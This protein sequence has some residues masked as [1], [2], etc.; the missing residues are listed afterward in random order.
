MSRSESITIT[1]PECKHK[2]AIVVWQSINATLNPELKEQLLDRSLFTFRCAKCGHVASVEQELMY[3]D[4]DQKL[5]ILR[6]KK[7]PADTL[8]EAFG[9]V[10]ET[11]QAE[12]TYRLVN[13]I[14]D[15]IEKILIWDAGLDDRVVEVVKILL[16][17]H[18]E[19]S[20]QGENAELFFGEVYIEDQTEDQAEQEPLKQPSK[21]SEKMVEFVLVN[22][23]GST[24]WAVPFDA[25][26]QKCDTELRDILPDRQSECGK[27]LR[28]DR[29]YA[30][31]YLEN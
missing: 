6:G 10:A 30:Q 9:P 20:E 23:S 3:H 18:I 13:S 8:A 24:A 25:T 31:Q 15:L 2:Q 4:M 22:A 26:V 17:D 1:C 7:E 11:V 12:Y 21:E 29:E 28:V 27:W 16:M 14:N 5:M 19:K